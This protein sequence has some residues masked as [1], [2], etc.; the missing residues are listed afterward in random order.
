[1]KGAERVI[2]SY[3]ATSWI[4]DLAWLQGSYRGV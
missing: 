2:A 3:R 4:F 1:M